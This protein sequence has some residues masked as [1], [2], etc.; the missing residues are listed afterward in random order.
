MIH[1]IFLVLILND[2]SERTWQADAKMDGLSV[3][4]SRALQE[5]SLV[6]NALTL[7]CPGFSEVG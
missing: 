2:S 1:L 4:K 5:A 6:K 3:Q 7:L